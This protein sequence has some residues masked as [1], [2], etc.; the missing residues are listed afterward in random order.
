MSRLLA[1]AINIKSPDCE[2]LVRE[3]ADVTGESITDAIHSAVRERLTREKLRKLGS[4][5][6]S[7]QRIERIQERIRAFAP[8]EPQPAGT[9]ADGGAQP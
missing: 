2:R 4:V 1:M 3:L 9:M 7:W 6:R 5:E 8:V